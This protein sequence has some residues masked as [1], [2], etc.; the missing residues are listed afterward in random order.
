[1]ESDQKLIPV[2][3]MGEKVMVPE[4]ST[5]IDALEYAGFQLKK[6]IGC[7]E[8]FCGACA[9]VYRLPGDFKLIGGLACQTVVE[10][11]MY[12]AQ[13]PCTPAQKAT[14]NI[15]KENPDVSSFLKLYPEVFRCVSCNTCTKICPQEIEVMDYVNAI[16]RGDIAE[17]ADLS[18]DCIMCGLCTMRCPAEMAQYNIALL[19]RR[20]FGRYL[21]KR[22]DYLYERL[23]DI[24]DGKFDKEMKN[25]KQLSREGLEKRYKER[26]LDFDIT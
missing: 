23:K 18:F 10:P 15:E 20:L 17:A 25:I 6:G 11:G 2:Y 12:L 24:A 7:R 3:I 19:A 22:S 5:I 21:T 4:G 13:I 26:D 8:G 1:M 14:Y 9:T 16:I